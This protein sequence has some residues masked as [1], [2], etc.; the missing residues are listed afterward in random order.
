MELD[1]VALALTEYK[2]GDI[3]GLS[4][5]QDMLA[6]AGRGLPPDSLRAKIGALAVAYLGRRIVDG[7]VLHREFLAA[8]VDLLSRLGRADGSPD[9][10]AIE[11]LKS[12]VKLWR[13]QFLACLQEAQ[14]FLNA[15]AAPAA[16]AKINPSASAEPVPAATAGPVAPKMEPSSISFLSEEVF[17]VFIMDAKER[18]AFAQELCLVQEKGGNTGETVQELFRIFHT[19]KG[20][21]GFF[22]LAS[23]GDLAHN[24]ESL[25]DLVRQNK[26]VIDADM[27]DLLLVGIDRFKELLASLENQDIA[28][29]NDIRIDDLKERIELLTSPV[30]LPI[31]ERLVRS[32]AISELD[33]QRV[34]QD[35]KVGNFQKT[36]GEITV[37]QGLLTREEVEKAGTTGAADGEAKANPNASAFTEQY[38][39]VQASQISYLV[40]MIGELTIAQSQLRADDPGLNQLRKITREIQA[41]ALRLRTTKLKL[42]FINMR[43]GL[44]DVAK[45]LDK[46]VE[47]ET[48]G[49][50]IEVDRNLV[51]TLSEPL[52]H[53]IRN[54]VHHGIEAAAE[55]LAAG[56]PASGRVTLGAERRG[57]T[58][59]ISISDDGRGL[60]R[61]R[62]LEK[63]LQRGLVGTDRAD[64]LTDAEIYN[65]IFL[66]GFST[67]QEVGI[68]SG[69]GVGMD[70][71]KTF[72][73][74]NRGKIDLHT[75]PGRS[76]RIDLIF[77]INTAIVDGMIVTVGALTMVIPVSQV[78]ETMT[79]AGEAIHPV[80]GS[81]DILN[82]RGQMLPVINLMRY[83]GETSPDGPVAMGVVV[84]NALKD[85]F[86]F[87]VDRIIGKQ[88][89]V[90]KSLGNRFQDLK[91]INSGTALS[92]GRIAY[93]LDSE[94]IINDR[95]H[96]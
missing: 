85:R 72:V 3:L 51:E 57:N 84:E 90:I 55:R 19:F 87:G 28:I 10:A 54:S 40:D 92:G 44:R 60:E 18:L 23:M 45:K 34:L 75:E 83:F 88:E 43:R 62:I 66:P 22:K 91:A 41:S 11:D 68:I 96:Q 21:C 42:L 27:T 35:Q 86:V 9:R 65:F 14:S 82:R 61:D 6:E 13:E 95:N 93:V 17:R 24:F 73:A 58:I 76:T 5:I 71:V 36:F 77:P 80:N 20:E 29:F 8:T 38:I 69:R 7:Q 15:A 49:E 56:K 26:L 48:F 46:S 74:N 1:R 59:A 25:L 47:F 79:L 16:A 70:I 37:G 81:V 64:K 31:G 50:D 89:V 12:S 30:H 2:E 53:I 67:S 33:R 39:K 63:A 94:F 32:G 4:D 52:L 78:I